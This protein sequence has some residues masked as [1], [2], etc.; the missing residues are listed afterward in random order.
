MSTCTHTHLHHVYT[1]VSS[2][3]V[4]FEP[5][6]LRCSDR[7]DYPAN[8]HAAHIPSQTSVSGEL[9][10]L[11]TNP[12]PSH[13][14]RY[15]MDRHWCFIPVAMQVLLHSFHHVYAVKTRFHRNTLG[16]GQTKKFGFTGH[17]SVCSVHVILLGVNERHIQQNVRWGKRHLLKVLDICEEV[18]R[19]TRLWLLSKSSSKSSKWG[20][21]MC[22]SPY[23][24]VI[25]V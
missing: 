14:Y 1:S 18:R 19:K 20:E 13:T 4:Q 16:Q 24:F 10:V 23:A 12:S 25:Y 22:Y 21:L 17:A 2:W 15:L 9:R 8:P 5:E 6:D 11:P 7:G 3:G